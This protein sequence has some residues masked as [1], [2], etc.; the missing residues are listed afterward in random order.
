MRLMLWNSLLS[1]WYKKAT[2]GSRRTNPL[3]PLPS[4]LAGTEHPHSLKSQ[5]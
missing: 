5:P 4:S 2:E 1:S 3:H